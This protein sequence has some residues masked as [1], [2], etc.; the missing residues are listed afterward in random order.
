MA[1]A[2]NFRNKIVLITGGGS[3]IGKVTAA[4]FAR[5]RAKVIIIGRNAKRLRQVAGE[6]G[7][8]FV[9]SD[10][11]D[12]SK[13]QKLV[14]RVV[15]KHKRIDILVNC[16]GIYGPIGEFHTNALLKWR[17]AINI[18]LL[19]TV[20]MC[21][22]VLPFMIRQKAGNI[23]NLSGGGAVQPFANFSAYAT[24]KAAVVRFTENLAKEYEKYNIQINAIAPGAINTRFLQQVLKAGSK[25]AGAD[26]YSKSLA[27]NKSGGDD[28]QLAADLILFLCAS[29][30]TGKLISAKWD[31][32]RKWKV[33]DV[34]SLN[35]SSEYTLRRIDNKYFFE[36]S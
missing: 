20:N 10:V 28:P 3:G 17:E 12:S 16:A 13:A 23:I 29:K 24:S 19:G 1:P 18:N 33:K 14:K 11:T 26:F 22:A 32:W 2:Y 35:Q 9:S 30:L 21:H 36:K 25:K 34:K 6:I 7:A 31:P 4:N 5:A 27:Q 8:T 15:K